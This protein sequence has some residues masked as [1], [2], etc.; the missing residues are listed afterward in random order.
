MSGPLSL[1]QYS[2]ADYLAHDQ[3]SN[4]KHEFLAGE[5]YAMAVG[6]PK[7]AALSMA[8]GASLLNQL[9]GGNCHVYSSDL[10]VRVMPPVSPPIRTSRLCAV[11][12]RWTPRAASPRPIPA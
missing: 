7:H 1:H 4:T 6:T 3:A 11:R 9:T 12:S 5:I 2:Y 10:R 8:V